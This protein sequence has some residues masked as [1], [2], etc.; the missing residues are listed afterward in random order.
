MEVVRDGLSAAELFTKECGVPVYSVTNAREMFD[1][2]DASGQLNAER[3]KKLVSFL[4]EKCNA[5][6]SAGL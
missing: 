1:Y 5:K 2:L 6:A 4:K 3:K